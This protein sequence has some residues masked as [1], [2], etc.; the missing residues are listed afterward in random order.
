MLSVHEET[1]NEI[2]IRTRVRSLQACS[3]F[4]FVVRSVTKNALEHDFARAVATVTSKLNQL[5][6]VIYTHLRDRE[7]AERA[8]E[9]PLIQW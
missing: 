9:H 4:E 5:H 7:R 2:T 3:N 1:T 6:K 8:S